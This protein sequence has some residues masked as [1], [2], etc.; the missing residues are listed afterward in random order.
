MIMR[1][2]PAP[3][4][5]CHEAMGNSRASVFSVRI[6]VLVLTGLLT[7]L[8]GCSSDDEDS[9]DPATACTDL[10]TGAGFSSS[11]VDAHPHETNCFCTGNGTVSAAACT[12]MCTSLG[13]AKSEPFGN[14]AQGPNACQC[15]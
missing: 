12:N 13:K 15:S 4:A 3:G 2:R 6:A 5:W 11:R 14:G 1:Y 10:C 9:K 8:I 7:A